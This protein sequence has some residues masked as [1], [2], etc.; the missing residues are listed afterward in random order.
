MIIAIGMN[1]MTRNTSNPR[2]LKYIFFIFFYSSV[3]VVVFDLSMAFVYIAHI[4]QSV[5][6]GM[7]L[8]YSGWSVE[9]KLESYDEFAGWIPITAS[10]LWMRGIVFLGMNIYCCKK[11]NSIRLKIKKREFKMRLMA[12]GYTP[13]PY[14]THDLTQPKDKT[15]LY[16]RTGEFQP[17]GNQTRNSKS[18]FN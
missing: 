2:W 11:V 6:K 18:Y 9:L 13:I 4:Q 14:P 3:G 17:A 7:I 5:T 1:I 12:E 8:R 16:Y 10:V 15:V